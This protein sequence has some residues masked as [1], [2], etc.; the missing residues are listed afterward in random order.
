MMLQ[1]ENYSNGKPVYKKGYVYKRRAK[2]YSLRQ[3]KILVLMLMN[4]IILRWYKYIVLL[5]CCYLLFFTMVKAQRVSTSY[6]LSVHYID[7]DTAFTPV[8]LSLQTRFTDSVQCNTYIQKLQSLLHG[9]GY[10][11]ASIDS[12]WWQP[13]TT[14]IN[15]YLGQQY[16]WVQLTT[17]GIDKKALLESGYMERHFANNLLNITQLQSLQQKLLL[18]YEKNGYPFAQVYLDSVIVTNEQ[19]NAALKVNTGI[20]YHIDS[21]RII[22]NAKIKNNFLQR[23]LNIANNSIYNTQTLQQ[24]S[25]RILELPIC[26][27]RNRQILPCLA[28]A[29]Y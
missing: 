5:C 20:L 16:R 2:N 25:Q 23:Y 18:Y 7:K 21:I 24:V 17:N 1:N 11:A 9:K 10:P 13:D 19:I 3:D 15:L 27:S 29:Q 8:A 12:T 6:V 4:T 22:G 14:H 26:R 28:P